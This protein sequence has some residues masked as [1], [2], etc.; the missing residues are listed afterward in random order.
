MATTRGSN[1]QQSDGVSR[2][3][4]S[5]QRWQFTAPAVLL[6]LAEGPSH[7]YQL[8]SRL[9]PMLPRDAAPLDAAGVYRV[10]HGLESGGS[11]RSSWTANPGSGPARR[12][13]ELTD[14]GRNTLDSWACSI[15][16]EIQAMSGLL[17]AYCR[18]PT[19]HHLPEPNQ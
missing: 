16:C 7:G 14:S 12:V 13:Y 19:E 6:L 2:P 3:G 10:L 9:R 1:D 5:R 18:A 4:H 17:A 8:L 11:L 15:A